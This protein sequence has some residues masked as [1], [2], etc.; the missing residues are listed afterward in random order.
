[1]GK[2]MKIKDKSEKWRMK[3]FRGIFKKGLQIF[4]GTE[5]V[6]RS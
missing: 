5:K 3:V 6:K 4:E 2:K 1:V